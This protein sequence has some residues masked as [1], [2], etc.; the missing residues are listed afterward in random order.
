MPPLSDAD[1]IAAFADHGHECSLPCL[2][3]ATVCLRN[4]EKHRAA[5]ANTPIADP[6]P[7]PALVPAERPNFEPLFLAADEPVV[8]ELVVDELAVEELVVDE[9][10][11]IAD[12]FEEGID[13]KINDTE[14][15]VDEDVFFGTIADVDIDMNGT[16]GVVDE[17]A[18]V[19]T[20]ADV[21]MNLS[22]WGV[23]P[24]QINAKELKAI[25][26][27]HSPSNILSTSLRFL[28]RF[29]NGGL[30]SSSVGSAVQLLLL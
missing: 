9:L 26:A 1:V 16:E 25:S 19:G 27:K 3:L 4:Q 28:I 18:V 23:T 12:R 30:G 6:M 22:L 20:I 29:A 5:I 7:T 24:S 15:T 21:E 17:D 14:G 2:V 13:M 8:D 10:V 11:A